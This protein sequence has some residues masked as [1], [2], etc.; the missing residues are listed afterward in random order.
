MGHHV[1]RRGHSRLASGLR[2][3]LWVRGRHRRRLPR[4]QP[5]PLPQRLRGYNVGQHLVRLRVRVRLRLRVWVRLRLR[6]RRRRR[7]KLRGAGLDDVG[8]HGRQ[9]T[10]HSKAHALAMLGRLTAGAAA[11]FAEGVSGAC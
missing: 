6:R 2:L 11:A 9:R 5:P 10:R 8:Q 4:A 7:R 1:R 3:R